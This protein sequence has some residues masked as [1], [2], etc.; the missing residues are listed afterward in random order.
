M[1]FYADLS[2]PIA[3]K[4]DKSRWRALI[5]ALNQLKLTRPTPI[6]ASGPIE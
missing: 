2:S 4:K 1:R 3:T 6:L 5:A